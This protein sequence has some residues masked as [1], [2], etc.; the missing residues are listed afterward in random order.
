MNEFWRQVRIEL[1]GWQGGAIENLVEDESGGGSLEGDFS[2]GHL[3]EDGAEGEEVCADIEDFA[4]RLLGRHIGGG[5]HGDA[6]RGL[7]LRAR[8]GWS[9]GGLLVRVALD[10][11]ETEVEYF[12][13]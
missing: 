7:V 2:G 13:L 9:R 11:G 6:G 1:R 8:E 12:D 3:V 4:A 5:S 10:F